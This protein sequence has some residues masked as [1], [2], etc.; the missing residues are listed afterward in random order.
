MDKF[1]ERE[2]GRGRDEQF[3]ALATSIMILQGEEAIFNQLSTRFRK[4]ENK[5]FLFKT[6][7]TGF[8]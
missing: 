5:V 3:P 2:K 7:S 8:L 1:L 6:N 4:L